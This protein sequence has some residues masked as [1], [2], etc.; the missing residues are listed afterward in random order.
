M[1]GY[2]ETLEGVARARWAA[3][4]QWP[5]RGVGVSWERSVLDFLNDVCEAGG[6]E[7][8]VRERVEGDLK[9]EN[10]PTRDDE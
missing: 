10:C 2:I 9:K 3:H 1:C 5:L 4:W 7:G 6:R 8:A